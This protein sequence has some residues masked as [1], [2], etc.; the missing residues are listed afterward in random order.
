MAR[1]ESRATCSS[2][3]SPILR[4]HAKT[5]SKIPIFGLLVKE[6]AVLQS[7]I[8]LKLDYILPDKSEKEHGLCGESTVQHKLLIF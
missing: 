8:G 3:R 5:C 2:R 7:R 1:K 6:G 4:M